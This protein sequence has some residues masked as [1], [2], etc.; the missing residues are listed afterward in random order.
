MLMNSAVL[1]DYGRIEPRRTPLPAV[2]EGELLVR[3]LATGICGSDLAT[4]RGAHPYKT[5]P[6]VLGHELCGTVERAAGGFA[7]GDLVCAAAYSHCGSCAM[8]RQGRTNLCGA[9]RNLCHLGWD[10]SF[11]EYVT[12]RPN[13]AFR[14]PAGTDPVLGALVEP[15]SIAVHAVNLAGPAQGRTLRVI[16]AGNIGLGCLIAARRLGYG[17]VVCSDLGPEKGRRAAALGADGYLDVL[18]DGGGA[19]ATAPEADV[20]M[21]ASSHPGA[22][23]E[24]VQAVR[25]G[26]TVVVVSFFDRPPAVA[27]NALVGKEVQVVGSSLSTAEDF[28]T[29]ISWLAEGTIDPM[30]MVTHRF[31]LSDADA[32]MRLMAAGEPA[33]GKIIITPRGDA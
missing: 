27:V 24:A 7:A 3:V 15:L 4:F 28:R 31:E 16:G 21:V 9:K 26:G 5:A 19:A 23:D 1:A 18:A 22:V 25:P 20:V 2:A 11:A 10:G 6:T 12:L 14:L 29:V 33:T 8:C 17:R 32:A 30:P 13:M